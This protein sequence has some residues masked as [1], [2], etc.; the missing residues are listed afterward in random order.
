[1]PSRLDPTAT[2]FLPSYATKSSAGQQVEMMVLY[3][4]TPT[5]KPVVR[6]SSFVLDSEKG[7]ST[8]GRSVTASAN[9]AVD[10]TRSGWTRRPIREHNRIPFTELKFERI[11]A[12]H[13]SAK[14]VRRSTF[15]DLP[16]EIRNSI[17]RLVLVQD[18]EYIDLSPKTNRQHGENK[19]ARD[20]H[21][22]RFREEITPCLG[23]L[24]LNKQIGSESAYIFYGETEFR[25]TSYRGW[26][27]LDSWLS[28]IGAAN[29][30]LILNNIGSPG[31]RFQKIKKVL[32]GMGLHPRT[33]L[34][35]FCLAAPHSARLLHSVRAIQLFAETDFNYY[36]HLTFLLDP[37]KFTNLKIKLVRLHGGFVGTELYEAQYPDGVQE[38]KNVMRASVLKEH[39]PIYKAAESKGVEVETAVYNSEG[40][41]PVALPEGDEILDERRCRALVTFYR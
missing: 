7:Q 6:D 39:F 4:A 37:S 15:V 29:H 1:M 8:M 35:K 2:P 38:N 11:S 13:I 3:A 25:F 34:K 40:F 26:Y 16:A 41:H 14:P 36:G 9:G 5:S 21:M 12:E 18:P 33:G 30:A 24:R 27:T 10:I 32:V 17:Y 28:K 23:M 19:D 31:T 20:H 22:K